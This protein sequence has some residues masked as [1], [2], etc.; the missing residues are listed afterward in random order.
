VNRGHYYS[1][2]IG[3]YPQFTAESFNMG[4]NM[5]IGKVFSEE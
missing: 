5:C 3:E 1:L 2:R 4:G